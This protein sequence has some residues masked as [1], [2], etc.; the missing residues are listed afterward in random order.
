MSNVNMPLSGA[1]SQW[2]EAWA[3]LFTAFGS[4]F[5]LININ[6]GASAD[7]Q[8]E[9]KVVNNVASYGKQL[10]RVEDALL[11]LLRHANL[12]ASLPPEQHRAIEDL[13]AMLNEIANAK[14]ASGAKHVLR[15]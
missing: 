13:R 15:P 3:S 5:G 14:E 10:G 8:L 12:P 2:I 7:P 11:V 1:V 9:T 4:Q 6:L